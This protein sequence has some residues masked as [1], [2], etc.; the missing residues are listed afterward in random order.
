MIKNKLRKWLEIPESKEI[1]D[2]VDKLNRQ[3]DFWKRWFRSRTP[4]KK[5]TKCKQPIN[6]WPFN[7]KLGYYIKGNKVTHQSCPSRNKS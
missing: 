2:M 5:C 1:Q 7:D 3:L 4:T 6:L